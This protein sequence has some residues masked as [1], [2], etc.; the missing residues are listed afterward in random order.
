MIDLS[1]AS[2]RV[3]RVSPFGIRFWDEVTRKTIGDGLNVTAYPLARPS[4]RLAAFTCPSGAYAFRN[5]PGLHDFE[6]GEGGQE[7]WEEIPSR[8][9]VIEVEDTQ[10]RFLPFSLN[11][12]L[13]VRDAFV[14]EDPVTSPLESPLG[15]PLFSAP[16]RPAPPSMAVLRASLKDPS[17]NEGE[18][19]PAAWAIVEAA[20]NGQV[21]ARGIADASGQL[22][23]IFPYP[24]PPIDVSDSP[25]SGSA[26]IRDQV[27]TIELE[28]RYERQYPPASF[29]GL[30]AILT[31]A[32]A[33]L[34]RDTDYSDVLPVQRLTFGQE[35]IVR[36]TDSSTGTPLSEL[37]VT[38]VDSPPQL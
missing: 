18:G 15:V 2:E 37:L 36:S 23:M 22:L 17:L 16:S 1:Q 25:P 33:V 29:P 30:D 28:A 26:S 35:L 6:I 4:R 19:G 21:S 27:W 11:V 20:V 24:A 13:P 3:T 38:P 7:F 31:Q 34:W 10:R 8:S 12:S 14:W 9:F 32:P 5:L